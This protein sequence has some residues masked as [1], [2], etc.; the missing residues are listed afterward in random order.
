MIYRNRVTAL[1]RRNREL[2]NLAKLAESKN[3]PTVL[4]EIADAAVGKPRQPLPGSVKDTEVNNTVG[5]LEAANVVSA[6]YVEKVQK[7]SGRHEGSR[8]SLFPE[9]YNL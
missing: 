3:S 6:Y 8:K 5:N 1:V 9:R 2:S 7:N 4:W